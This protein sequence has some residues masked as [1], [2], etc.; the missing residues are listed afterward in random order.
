MKKVVVIDGQGGKIGSLI[1]SRLK[2]EA[3]RCEVF[4]VSIGLTNEALQAEAFDRGVMAEISVRALSLIP[5]I[6]P[7]WASG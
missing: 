6:R 3:G 2:A 4:A 5:S 7:S 1:V